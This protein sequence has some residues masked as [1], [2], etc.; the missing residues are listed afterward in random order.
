MV[1]KIV[2]EWSLLPVSGLLEEFR[3]LELRRGRVFRAK[4]MCG[5][6]TV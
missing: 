3:Y 2:L 4:A 6:I 1:L 5:G